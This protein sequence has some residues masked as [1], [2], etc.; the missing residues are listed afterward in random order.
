[1]VV[2]LVLI[3]F[4]SLA[5]SAIGVSILLKKYLWKRG[6]EE[7]KVTAA[8]VTRFLENS[9]RRTGSG[10]RRQNSRPLQ[11][12]LRRFN[13]G[14]G[15]LVLLK[16]GE[17]VAGIEESELDWSGVAQKFKPGFHQVE[18]HDAQ[19]QVL[20]REVDSELADGFAIIRP[21][22]PSL[23]VVRVL[24]LYQILASILVMG[25][26]MGA[27][28]YFAS[29]L[30]R[31]LEELRDSTED[32]G[33]EAMDGLSPSSVSEIAELQVSFEKMSERVE[34][35]MASQ[36]RFVADASHE[37]KT[38]LTAISGMLELVQTRPDMEAEDRS[39]ALAVARKEAE[40]M[41]SLIADLLLLSRAQANRSGAKSEVHLAD[42]VTEQVSTLQVLFPEQEFVTEG[43][44][45]IR[46]HMNPDGFS[47]VARNLI[48][49]A[50]HYGGGSP[51]IL[52]FSNQK[53]GIG[54]AVKDSGPGIPAEKLDKL[55]ERFY[56]TDSGRARSQ[57]GHGL[58]LAIVKALVEEAGGELTCQSEE[59]KGTE[60]RTFF[61]KS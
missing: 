22:S 2:G 34:Q 43:D 54:F 21:W 61:R 41:E 11:R 15:R 38:P 52:K 26:A 16:G 32:V 51:I 14:P 4:L 47:R 50:C 39:Q 5:A 27:V 13:R 46:H 17:I 49:N 53:S 8:G 20:T 12:T 25:L 56:R 29:R 19:W 37:L 18:F 24:V 42:L 10:V 9:N 30:A 35:A 1:M 55:F 36:R 57:G 33:T 31:P 60:F 48:E 58:G 44:T 59:G 40:R 3:L 23:R 28:L 6:Q 45:N 7:S